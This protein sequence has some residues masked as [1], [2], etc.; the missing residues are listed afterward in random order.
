MRVSLRG[1]AWRVSIR[2]TTHDALRYQKGCRCDECR[3]AERQRKARY[4]KAKA[5]DPRPC[6]LEPT[7]AIRRIQALVCAGWTYYDI[8]AD[9]KLTHKALVRLVRREHGVSRRD[10]AR[11][12]RTYDRLWNGPTEM[13]KGRRK[14]QTEARAKGWVAPM[15]WDDDLIDDPLAEPHDEAP[16]DVDWQAV[17]RAVTGTPS[18]R[19][20]TQAERR[21]AVQALAGGGATATQISKRLGMNSGDVKRYSGKEAA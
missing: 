13:T 11:I 3:E 12:K 20:L 19:R 2:M 4:R 17:E 8:A 10:H 9:A 18:G 5:I 1:K 21:A 6:Y 7:G 14:A 15:G 16:V